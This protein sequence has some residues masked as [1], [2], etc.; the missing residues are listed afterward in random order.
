[1]P[2]VA[3]TIIAVT[4]GAIIGPVTVGKMPEAS[5]WGRPGACPRGGWTEGRVLA[6]FASAGLVAYSLGH[7]HGLGPVPGKAA[8]MVERS[9]PEGLDGA[10][11]GRLHPRA[12]SNT[13]DVLV[14]GAGAAGLT[15]GRLLTDLGYRVIVLEA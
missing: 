12:T 9:E 2:R 6:P 1:M 4:P 3:H 14:I 13:A 15:A 10:A 8:G 5:G 11:V 7:S